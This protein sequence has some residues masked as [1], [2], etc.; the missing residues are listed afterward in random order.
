MRGPLF[1]SAAFIAAVLCG[2]CPAAEFQKIMFLGEQAPGTSGK[3]FAGPMSAVIGDQGDVAIRANTSSSGNGIWRF[4]N[5]VL[6]KIAATGDR[7]PNND[8]TF[9]SFDTVTLNPTGNIAFSA[10]VNSPVL[11]RGIWTDSTGSL[12]KAVAWGDPVPG[13]ANAV[14]QFGLAPQFNQDQSGHVAFMTQ[15]ANV[16]PFQVVNSSNDTGV[17]KFANGTLSKILREGDAAP[18][19]EAGV[20]FGNFSSLAV[21]LLPRIVDGKVAA[22]AFL[23]GPGITSTNDTGIW[24]GDGTQLNKIVREGDDAPEGGQFVNVGSDGSTRTGLGMT[25]SGGV[26][27]MGKTSSGPSGIW[28]AENGAIEPIV[29]TGQIAPGTG[30]SFFTLSGPLT[31]PSGR[32]AFWS[33]LQ[34]STQSLWTWSSGQLRAVITSADTPPELG[35]AWE[36]T[37]LAGSGF[38]GTEFLLN[39]KGQMVFTALIRPKG[40]INTMISLWGFD[41]GTGI[42]LIARGGQQFDVGGG[43]LRTISNISLITGSASGDGRPNSLNDQGQLVV[44]LTFSDFSSGVFLTAVPEPAGVGGLLIFTLIF[45]RRTRLR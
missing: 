10:S 5:N 23:T 24:L 36:F 4:H 8:P 29:K 32:I 45:T 11:P 6:S 18:Q 31:S 33:N 40:Q 19:T 43:N 20:S 7:I 14:F 25:G 13:V 41:P 12:S 2:I 35:G 21:N 15:L 1:R 16:S 17:W 39:D 3:T 30:S 9:S 28:K 38:D 34:N 26:V 27:F 42:H 22:L 44:T 37:N